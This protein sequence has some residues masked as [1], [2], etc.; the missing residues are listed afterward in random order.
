MRAA[1]LVA[2]VPARYH[3]VWVRTLLET[4]TLRDDTTF[5]RWMQLGSLH[6][7]VRVPVNSADPLQGFSGVTE[8]IEAYDGKAETCQWHRVVDYQP[9]RPDPDIGEM[10]FETPER[11]IE[12][13]IHGVYREVWER[14]PQSTGPLIALSQRGAGEGAQRTRVLIAGLYL[15]RV[16]PLPEPG[17]AFEIS[18]AVREGM[19]STQWRVERSTIRPLEGELFTFAPRLLDTATAEVD[20]GNS[21][22]QWDVLEWQGAA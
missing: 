10:V 2:P 5:V 1:P 19:A 17:P 16:K 20:Y 3:G 9:P 7:D 21:S 12:T 6:A 13:G 22:S 14:L 4:P 18:F 15:M 8:V 11:V